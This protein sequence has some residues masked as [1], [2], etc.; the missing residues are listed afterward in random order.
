MIALE[1]FYDIINSCVLTIASA[2][3]FMEFK[4]F[5]TVGAKLSKCSMFF[6]QYSMSL[7]LALVY[8]K[9]ALDC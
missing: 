2:P 9:L 6:A 1:Q 4:N 5:L 7:I 8:P 3:P